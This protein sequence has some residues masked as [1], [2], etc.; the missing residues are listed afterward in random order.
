MIHTHTSI[1]VYIYI[2]IVILTYI[3]ICDMLKSAKVRRLTGAGRWAPTWQLQPGLFAT[4]QMPWCA[5]VGPW[6]ERNTRKGTNTQVWSSLITTLQE[7]NTQKIRIPMNSPSKLMLVSFTIKF[8]AS[9]VRAVRASTLMTRRVRKATGSPGSP[10]GL[11]FQP[12][13]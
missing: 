13:E 8:W 4:S 5:T 2:H 12:P 9:G 3:Y 7:K 1:C 6:C 11:T 10:P